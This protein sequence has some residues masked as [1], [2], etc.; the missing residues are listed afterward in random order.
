MERLLFTLARFT[1]PVLLVCLALFAACRQKQPPPVPPP[2]HEESSAAD[3]SRMASALPVLS[4]GRQPGFTVDRS[5]EAAA[6]R[7]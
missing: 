3:P 5:S 7:D 1:L 6:Y 4:A 2:T